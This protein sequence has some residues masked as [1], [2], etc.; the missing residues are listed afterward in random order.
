MKKFMI[1]AAAILSIGV[2]GAAQANEIGLILGAAIPREQTAE[3][4]IYGQKTGWEAGVFYLLDASRPLDF[5]AD[6][7]HRQLPN[8][9]K[10]KNVSSMKITEI[11]VNAK[12]TTCDRYAVKPY[13]LAGVGLAQVNFLVDIDAQNLHVTSASTEMTIKGGIGADI[14]LSGKIGLFAEAQ[15]WEGYYVSLLPVRAGLR[16]AI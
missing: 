9:K 10:I 4:S 6:L 15:L 1:V 2:L 11:S 7:T 16:L 14:D 5:R 8:Y 13:L 3:K 12:L